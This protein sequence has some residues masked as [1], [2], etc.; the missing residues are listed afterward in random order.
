VCDAA[1]TRVGT[2]S[3][4]GGG[5]GVFAGLDVAHGGGSWAGL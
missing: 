1:T 2:D 5:A 4:L 3:G